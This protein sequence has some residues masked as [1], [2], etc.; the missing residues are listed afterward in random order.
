VPARVH[1]LV[2]TRRSGRQSLLLGTTVTEIV[3][4]PAEK[5][6]ALLDRLLAWSAQP[7]FTLRHAW[8]LGDL[9]MWDN[10]AMVHRALPFGPTSVRLTHRATVRGD[11][12]VMAA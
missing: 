9:V 2:W 10:T 6:R 7:Q 11:E 1:P 4:W 3:G 5:G 8:R 12:P